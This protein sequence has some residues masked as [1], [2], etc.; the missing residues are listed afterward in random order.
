MENEDFIWKT[1]LLG[2]WLRFV[3]MDRGYSQAQLSA[4]A[5]VAPSEIHRVEVGQQECRIESLV[6]LCGP[7]GITP[8]WILDR[9]A[10]SNLSLFSHKIIGEPEFKELLRRIGVPAS[11]IEKNI[12]LGLACGAVLAAILARAS[13]PV[14]DRAAI[15]HNL[16]TNPMREL[17]AQGLVV[18]RIFKE[19]AQARGQFGWQPFNLRF[20]REIKWA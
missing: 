4:L 1:D 7:L 17:S 2:A 8:G 20:P 9:V 16:L 12:S 14:L 13:C 19:T 5:Q 18:D 11:D 15:L 6:K 10:G 3:R